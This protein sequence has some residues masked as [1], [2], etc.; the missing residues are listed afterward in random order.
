LRTEEQA[1]NALDRLNEGITIDALAQA[2]GVAGTVDRGWIIRGQEEPEVEAA[3]FS[4]AEGERSGVIKAANGA[5]YIV[6]VVEKAAERRVEQSQVIT[7][8]GSTFDRWV[9]EKKAGMMIIRD[10]SPATLT[11]ILRRV[12]G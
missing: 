5:F 10:E 9:R 7:A 8:Q 1:T 6:E 12:Q 2:A 11:K 4:L 3:A